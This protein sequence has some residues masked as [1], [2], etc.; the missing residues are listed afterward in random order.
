MDFWFLT[1]GKI[2]FALTVVFVF[3][4]FVQKHRLYYSFR[5]RYPEVARKEIPHVFNDLHHHPEKFNYFYRKK[6]I[7]VLKQDPELWRLRQQVM[8]LTILGLGLPVSFMVIGFVLGII[9][10]CYGR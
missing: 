2:I 4:L 3:A 10:M 5:K 6:A 7:P 9:A 1:F 8:I